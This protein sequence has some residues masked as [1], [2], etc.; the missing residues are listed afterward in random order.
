MRKTFWVN[1]NFKNVKKMEELIRKNK[2]ITRQE[3]A[4]I[5]KKTRNSIEKALNAYNIYL[6]HSNLIQTEKFIP[7]K[8]DFKLGKKEK[9]LELYKPVNWKIKKSTRKKD[10]NKGFKIYFLSADYHIPFQNISAVKAILQLLRRVIFDG[11]VLV[12]DYMDMTP[13][14]HWNEHQHLTLE[15]KRLKADYVEG[16]KLLDEFDLRLPKNCDKRYFMGNHER[17]YFDLIQKMPA[18]EDL[19]SPEI[20]L[21]LKERKYIVY[22]VNHIERIGKLSVCHGQYHNQNYV[23]KHINEFKTN[24]LHADMH[25]PRMRFETSP[26]KMLAI[27]GYCLGCMCDMNPTFMRNRAH[28][29][30]HGF[31]I[32]YLFEDGSFDIDLKR[33]VNGRFVFN[34]EVYDGNE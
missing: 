34:N 23:L 19:I 5:M 29:W 33:I 10:K 15:N 7:G 30:S 20:E 4:K 9:E 18:L 31:A 1:N 25:S 16:N 22:P 28:K 11:F 27:A 13:I 32:L 26:A 24:V 21:K 12:G 17:F 3:I 2:N 8:I 6:P 14:S